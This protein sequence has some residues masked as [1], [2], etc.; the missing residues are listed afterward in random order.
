MEIPQFPVLLKVQRVYQAQSS[1]LSDFSNA[2][3]HPFVS[4]RQV[5]IHCKGKYFFC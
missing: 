4:A 5:K 2:S 1:T 3:D